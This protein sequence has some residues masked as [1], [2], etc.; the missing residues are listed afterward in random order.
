MSCMVETSPGLAV[1]VQSW[2]AATEPHCS[3]APWATGAGEGPEPGAWAAA[4]P[5]AQPLCCVLSST[6]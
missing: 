4:G 3:P 5:K 1:S 6:V 2:G